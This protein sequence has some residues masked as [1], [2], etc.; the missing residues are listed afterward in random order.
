MTSSESEKRRRAGSAG[1]KERL[2]AVRRELPAW[3]GIL[4]KVHQGL[5]R[6]AASIEPSLWELDPDVDLVSMD[7]PTELRSVIS[8]V[9]EQYL[10]LAIEDLRSLLPEKES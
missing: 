5:V 2:A 4:E 8:N 6:G 9:A 7:E 3:I 1:Q 10:R